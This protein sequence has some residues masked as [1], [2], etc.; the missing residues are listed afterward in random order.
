MLIYFMNHAICDA[1]HTGLSVLAVIDDIAARLAGE[2][3]GSAR[4]RL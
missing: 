1:D 2:E 4:G 3:K